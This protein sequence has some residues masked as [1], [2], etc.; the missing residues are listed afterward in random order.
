MMM[1]MMK[2]KLKAL[3][4]NIIESDQSSKSLEY[5]YGAVCERVWS[6]LKTEHNKTCR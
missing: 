6:L 3:M 4:S 2:I 5:N 1:I